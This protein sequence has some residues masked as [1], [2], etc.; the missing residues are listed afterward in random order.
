SDSP[1]PNMMMARAIGRPTVISPESMADTMPQKRYS[2]VGQGLAGVRS[3]RE[4]GPMGE[5]SDRVE[6]AF[7]RTPRSGFLPEGE[8]HRA[9][10]DGPVTIGDDQTN[11]Q[12]STV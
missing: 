12:P 3:Q 1:R 5:V 2:S 6:Q 11:S 7:V 10:E 9:A 8:R 4:D